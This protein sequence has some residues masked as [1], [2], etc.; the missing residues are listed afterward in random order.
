MINEGWWK[1]MSIDVWGLLEMDIR[2]NELDFINSH[3]IFIYKQVLR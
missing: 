1:G 2:L 3:H